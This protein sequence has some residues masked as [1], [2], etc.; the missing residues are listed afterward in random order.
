MFADDTKIWRVISK[1]EDSDD[2]QQDLNKRAK[3][4]DKWL[5]RFNLEKCKVMHIGH[6][7]PT[8]YYMEENGKSRQLRAI[9]EEKDLG[10]YVTSDMKPSRQCA[11]ASHAEGHVSSRYDKKELQK[12]NCTWFQ[13]S[14]QQLHPTTPGI[15]HTSLVPLPGI[16][17]L[18]TGASPKTSNEISTGAEE[19]T[20][21]GEAKNTWS[22][23]AGANTS[24]KWPDWNVQDSDWQG[25]HWLYTV[26][27]SGTY[28]SQY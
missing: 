27:H 4:S 23:L 20:V 24:K 8:Q 5:L 3:W 28:S 26:F 15:L 19:Q 21:S 9:T 16:W 11:Q 13:D 18:I 6:V 12:N 10:V 14:L 25:E 22:V 17:H 1:A 2:L 7:H